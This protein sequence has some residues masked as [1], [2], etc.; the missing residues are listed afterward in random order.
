M[1]RKSKMA[2][3]EKVIGRKVIRLYIRV[4][5]DRQ[6]EEGYSLGIQE[7]KLRAYISTLM[8]NDEVEFDVVS[9]DGYSGGDLKRP[10]IQRIIEEAEGGKITHVVV[11]KLDR[12]SRSLKDT[13]HLIEDI[14][15]PHN[16]GFISLYESFDTSTPFGRAMIGILS[17]FAQFER[18]NIFERTRSGMQKR[19]EAGFWP[20]G[21]GIPFGYDY[22]PT[23]GILVP[24]AD[25]DKV[26][27]IYDKY[28][29]GGSLQT[30]ADQLGLKYEKVA[31]N[32]LTRKSNAGYIVYNGEEY[33]GR[34]E[35]IISLETYE[36]AMEMLAVRSAKKL[37]SK[38]AHLLTGLCVCGKCGAKMRYA[39]W[40]KGQ[41]KLVCYSQQTSK[42]YLIKDPNCDQA[43]LWSQDVEDAVLNTLFTAAAKDKLAEVQKSTSGGAIDDVLTEQLDKSTAKLKRLYTLYGESGDEILLSTINETKAEIARLEAQLRDEEEKNSYFKS[44]N[45]AYSRLENL[46]DVWPLMT[47]EERRAVLASVV[48][49]ITIS[50]NSIE[51]KLKYGLSS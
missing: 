7:E 23:Q 34:H 14:F 42:P 9:D 18:E 33:K 27:Y 25:A 39:P 13:M 4:S 28:L 48:E 46:Q 19:V 51:I 10:G 5:T 50:D 21:G 45:A 26:R 29:A 1:A 32:I 12:L 2:K 3:I 31:Y 6:A 16:V 17:V 22:D 49:T 47:T 8:D 38:S 37:V 41:H 30:I 40:G 20:G 15:L 44:A 36:Q 35:P 43:K 24:N 11:M